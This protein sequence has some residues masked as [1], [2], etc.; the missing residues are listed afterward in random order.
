M[1][2][3]IAIPKPVY[4]HF[5]Y[6]PPPG[7]EMSRLQPGIRL[8]V[9]FGK[10]QSEIG[11]LLAIAANSAIASH[12]LKFAEVILDNAPILP[13]DILQLLQWA[14]D[15]YHHP[16]GEVISTALPTLLNQGHPAII[17][18]IQGWKLTA[19][20]QKQLAS[21]AKTAHRQQAVLQLLQEHPHGLS[22]V[23]L[24]NSLSNIVP[25]LRTLEK[26]NW[27]TPHLV[28]P[29]HKTVQ[30]ISLPLPLN[31]AQTQAVNRVCQHLNCFYPSL[32][33]GV[34]GSGDRGLFTNYSTSFEPKSSS[35]S[36]NSGNQFN[37]P[38]G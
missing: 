5:D 29:I 12:K 23:T 9:P 36:V 33:D 10:N 31:A 32:L 1:I 38:N 16:L 19:N 6:L 22:H 18:A 27:I 11:I 7:I 28:E 20:G 4:T 15:Y 21:L 2:L 25:V 8:R 24:S 34:T 26:K 14:S 13:A 37:P 35:F 3:Q 30:S 17:Q